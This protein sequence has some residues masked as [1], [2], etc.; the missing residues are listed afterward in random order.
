MRGKLYLT[1]AI[2]C[3]VGLLVG[4]CQ[5]EPEP[6]P[7]LEVEDAMGAK[8]TALTY[9]HEQKGQDVPAADTNWAC[10]DI[11]TP[12]LVGASTNEFTA[13]GWTVRVRSPVVAPE[14]IIYTVTVT[15]IEGGWRWQGKVKPD[16]T[17]TEV[18]PV[19]QMS[20]EGSQAIAEEFVRNSPTFQYDGMEDTLMLTDTLTMRCPFCWTFIFE[21]DSR[22]AGYGNR[23][24][25]MLAQVI[26]HHQVLIAVDRHEIQSALMD[27]KWDMLTQKEIE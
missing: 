7:G 9:L 24:G 6:A 20:R 16:G 17:V 27:D 25:Q 10:A 13:N 14:N 5:G 8:D 2:L 4:A 23:T 11:T 15:H 12:G 3:L 21:F 1:G 18:S 22:A 19:T 26:T